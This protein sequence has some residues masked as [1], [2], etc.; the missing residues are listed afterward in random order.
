MNRIISRVWPLCLLFA[1]AATVVPGSARLY[2]DLAQAKGSSASTSPFRSLSACCSF[3]SIRVVNA[4]HSSR[5][6]FACCALL[7]SRYTDMADAVRYGTVRCG[8]VRL[9]RYPLCYCVLSLSAWRYAAAASLQDQ[10]R[11]LSL[12]A[13][14]PLFNLLPMPVP[15]A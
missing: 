3:R 5:L 8:A 4:L 11:S 2:L 13:R 12:I 9:T 10:C 15:A 7:L 6:C 1:A 14:P